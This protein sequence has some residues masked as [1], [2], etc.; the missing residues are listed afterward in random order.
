MQMSTEEALAYLEKNVSDTD[1]SPVEETATVETSAPVENET[2]DAESASSLEETVEKQRKTV[3]DTVHQQR[4]VDDTSKTDK[5]DKNRASKRDFAF[6]RE[7][8]KRKK[9]KEQYESR[10][11]ELESEL[12]RFKDL[13]LSDFKDNQEAYINY[14]L[15]QRE[16][17]RN[18]DLEKQR[19]Q[20]I[21]EEELTAE[22]ERRISL[23][24]PDENERKEYADLLETK[25]QDFLEALERFDP[26]NVVLTYLN[27]MEKYPVLLRKL[28]TDG[29]ALKSVFKKR[30]PM[31]RKLALE[32]LSNNLNRK[33]L[34]VIGRQIS[35]QPTSSNVRDINYWNNYLKEHPRGR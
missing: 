30:D 23:C 33:A 5:D 7:K 6:E 26:E 14:Q 12:E 11:K 29:E 2:Q 13:K 32:K 27:D 4:T 19:L 17:K 24:F 15:D 22:N 28:M 35:S 9:Q 34:P 18:I 8:A 21:Q 31:F 25:G 16:Q 1:Q 10:I 3:D 20:R